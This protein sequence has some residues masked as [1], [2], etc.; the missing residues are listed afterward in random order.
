[1]L[2]FKYHFRQG[3]RI[4]RYTARL[5]TNALRRIST[6]AIFKGYRISRPDVPVGITD[7]VVSVKVES[8]NFEVVVAI[9]ATVGIRIAIPLF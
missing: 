3:A 4:G 8:P 5:E 6:P 9:T 1:M 7:I 2:A